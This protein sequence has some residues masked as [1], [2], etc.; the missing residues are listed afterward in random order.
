ML[1]L[2]YVLNSDKEG[3]LMDVGASAIGR[4]V[5]MEIDLMGADAGLYTVTI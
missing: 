5:N 1:S 4:A 2:V 3:N